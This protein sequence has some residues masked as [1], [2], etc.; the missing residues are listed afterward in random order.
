MDAFLD[1]GLSP[2][3]RVRR[4]WNT[5]YFLRYWHRWLCLNKK[6]TAQENFIT[7]NASFGVELSGH[8]LITLLILMR[9]L[10]PN[11]N[12]LLCPWLLGS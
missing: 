1:K 11:G 4:V 5:I 6:F 7:S 2:L 9:D 3:E 12:E 8:A 10:I